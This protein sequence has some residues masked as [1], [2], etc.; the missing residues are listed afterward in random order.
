MRSPVIWVF[1]ASRADGVVL[2]CP[3]R[4]ILFLS[5]ECCLLCFSLSMSLCRS[6]RFQKGWTRSPTN[7]SS[8]STPIENG[9]NAL[10]SIP[11][12][13]RSSP[14]RLRRQRQ[15]RGPPQRWQMPR[16]RRAW[17]K[18]SRNL[19][20]P[21]PKNWSRNCS[22]SAKLQ[23]AALRRPWSSRNNRDLAFLQIACGEE[24]RRRE[25]VTPGRADITTSPCGLAELA[26]R[27]ASKFINSDGRSRG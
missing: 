17:V 18:H 22:G 24:P 19:C 11:A 14:H 15:G 27:S 3:W 20:R 12:F 10:F 26:V 1:H 21:N 9:P 4:D 16:R 25:T 5:V 8:E 13:R 6:Y 23:K 2:K 7:L